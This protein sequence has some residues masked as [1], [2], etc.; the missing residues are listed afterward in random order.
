[1]YPPLAR[2]DVVASGVEVD[3]V[4]R[5]WQTLLAMLQDAIELN[6]TEV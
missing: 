4:P 5:A 2:D 3:P 6:K 1:V